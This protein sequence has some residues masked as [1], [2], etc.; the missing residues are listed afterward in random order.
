MSLLKAHLPETVTWSNSE[1]KE[2]PEFFSS[3]KKEQEQLSQQAALVDFSHRDL[4]AI[5]G[6]ERINFLQG[7]I[8]NQIKEVRP[9]QSIYAAMLTPQGRFLWDFT[10]GEIEES[11]F[12][13]VEPQQGAPLVQS[14]SFYLM[15]TKATIQDASS[16]YGT[17]AV[18]GPQAD[19]EVAAFFPDLA[20]TDA[21]LGA[22]F[23]IGEGERLWRDPRHGGFGW[24][25]RVKA[26][27]YWPTWEKLAKKIP[28][29]G[30][31][32]WESFRIEQGL[33]KGGKEMIPNKSLPLE[34]G[35][36]EMNG[37]SFQKGC[38]VGQETTTRTYHRGTLKKRLF[39]VTL[40]GDGSLAEEMP[41]LT[42]SE[43]EAGTIT[44]AICQNG[45]CQGLA[46]L[47]VSDVSEG[48]Q[49]TVSGHPVTVHKPDWAG[50]E[51]ETP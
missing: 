44:S 18:V 21:P 1:G 20:I 17:L 23:T 19:Q 26:E 37:V 30:E 32:A 10:I 9:D 16:Q 15:R 36:L 31:A 6:P 24:K 42:P 40:E 4:V 25:I 7:L 49:L 29:A 13:D 43:K 12:L 45:K 27:N 51:T 48:K 22:T 11:L 33:P 47:R 2:Y 41:V 3:I 14:L 35:F 5:S 38:Y 34:A 50:W 8:T 28:P 39:R 46:L